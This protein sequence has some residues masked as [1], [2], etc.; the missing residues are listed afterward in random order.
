MG[1]FIKGRSGPLRV[2]GCGVGAILAGASALL[3]VGCA[4]QQSP[5]PARDPVASNP[6]SPPERAAYER[7][8]G[9]ANVPMYAL[10]IT[11]GCFDFPL[12][13]QMAQRLVRS[14]EFQ[15]SR[16][17]L[18]EDWAPRDPA[19]DPAPLILAVADGTVTTAHDH[20]PN[21]WG[22]V[23]R[24]VHRVPTERPG[25]EDVGDHLESIYAHL[26]AILVA[27]GERVERG[28]PL[29]TMGEAGWDEPHLHWELRE[30]MNMDI[31]QGYGRDTRG[32]VEPSAYVSAHRCL[33]A[34]RCTQAGHRDSPPIRIRVGL[35]RFR[36]L[37]SDEQEGQPGGTDP[38]ECHQERKC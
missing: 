22:N 18:G 28:Q 19:R 29:G 6:F 14:Q 37:R 10:P 38:H 8:L 30:R 20:G 11:D 32:Y 35:R 7:Y 31:G 4:P 9:T 24:V 16:H 2:A 34:H 23:V 26:D 3:L 36:H 1:I 5:S 12:G 13:A 21:G 33:E 25:F 15:S 27:P 17:H